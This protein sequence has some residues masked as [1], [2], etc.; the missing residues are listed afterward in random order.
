MVEERQRR[1]PQAVNGR[2]EYGPYRLRDTAVLIHFPQPDYSLGQPDA[3]VLFDS[4]TIVINELPG[5]V[6][7]ELLRHLA[8]KVVEADRVANMIGLPPPGTTGYSIEVGGE[9]DARDQPVV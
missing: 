3:Q 1:P 2:A 7:A 5:W 8:D 9:S 6:V 4:A